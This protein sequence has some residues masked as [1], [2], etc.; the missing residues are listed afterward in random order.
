M[1]YAHTAIRAEHVGGH[2]AMSPVEARARF[3]PWGCTFHTDDGGPRHFV[4]FGGQAGM[5]EAVYAL[6]ARCCSACTGACSKHWPSAW[7][8]SSTRRRSKAPDSLPSLTHSRLLSP[9]LRLSLTA[10]WS[11]PTPTKH[12][13]TWKRCALPSRTIEVSYFEV[14]PG[15]F[16]ADPSEF[17]AG[18]KSSFS[19]SPV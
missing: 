4:A 16:Q 15:R 13:V 9:P 7:I 14:R 11:A 2:V 12:A 6:W 5:L 19:C 3:Q 17:P 8:S 10:T 18:A 1:A